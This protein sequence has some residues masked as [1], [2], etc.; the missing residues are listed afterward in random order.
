MIP[1]NLSTRSFPPSDAFFVLGNLVEERESELSAKEENDLK[2]SL[3]TIL[4]FADRKEVGRYLDDF[5]FSYPLYTL[6]SIQK[7]QKRILDDKESVLRAED[8][9]KELEENGVQVGEEGYRAC[10]DLAYKLCHRRIY[11]PAKKPVCPSDYSLNFLWVNL[12]PQ[13]RVADL[14]QNIFGEGLDI[15]ESGHSILESEELVEEVKKTFTYKLVKWVELHERV[16]VN[17]WYDSALVTERAATNTFHMMERIAESKNVELKLRDIRTLS[18][19]P[20]AIQKAL[21]PGVNVYYRVDILKA[22]I[23]DFLMAESQRQFCVISDIDIAPIRPAALF[24]ERT[25]H[26]LNLHGYILCQLFDDEFQTPFSFENSFMMF[27]CK[28]QICQK[29]HREKII[30]LCEEH[31]LVVSEGKKKRFYPFLGGQ[32]VFGKYSVWTNELEKELTLFPRKLIDAPPSQFL[33]SIHFDDKDFKKEEFILIGKDPF[34]LVK[35]GRAF[36][37]IKDKKGEPLPIQILED[38]ECSPLPPP[39]SCFFA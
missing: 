36:S 39:K 2:E 32:S 20:P 1:D 9:L 35:Y 14:A 12:N 30:D 23:A 4:S 24:D 22:L 7:I 34:P 10:F 21:H 25:L 16:E 11:E 15:L 6:S 29:S 38:W 19:I 17:L 5:L 13:D 28:D 37:K 3:D 18:N 8:L 26:F 31:L 27:N 33:N